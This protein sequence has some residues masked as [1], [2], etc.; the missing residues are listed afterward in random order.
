MGGASA[1]ISFMPKTGTDLPSKYRSELRLYGRNYTL[2]TH[3]FLCYGLKEAER[4][5]LASL[6]QVSCFFESFTNLCLRSSRFLLP[7]IFAALGPRV[8]LFI[9]ISRRK[10]FSFLNYLWKNNP[11]AK[12]NDAIRKAINNLNT[13][14]LLIDIFHTIF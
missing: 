12:S 2:Y 4:R 13:I 1:E 8:T 6:V 9:R 3:S 11:S 14:Q 5:L 10:I 7:L